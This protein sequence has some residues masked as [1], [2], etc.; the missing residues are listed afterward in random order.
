MQSVKNSVNSETQT[1]PLASPHMN[2][3]PHH[4][5]HRHHAHHS[6]QSSAQG[7]EKSDKLNKETVVERDLIT[8][9]RNPIADWER[10]RGIVDRDRERRLEKDLRVERERREKL[11]E[12]DKGMDRDHRNEK[13]R[14][15]ER[16]RQGDKNEREN[17]DRSG[18][19]PSSSS[20]HQPWPNRTVQSQVH[21]YI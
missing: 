4:H 2:R 17:R 19:A 20:N 11:Q 6:S 14:R 9:G 3:R 15:P 8:D 7:R 12:R 1:S 10:D 5:H 13:E 21:F 16:E 18:G